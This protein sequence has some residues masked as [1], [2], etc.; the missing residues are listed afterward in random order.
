MSSDVLPEE[1]APLTTTL[2]RPV[3][4]SSST[5]TTASDANAGRSSDRSRKRRMDRHPPSGETGGMTAQT[6]DPSREAGVDDRCR[7]I[8]APTQR[9]QDALGDEGE[10]GG[11]DVARA[12]HLAVALDP[13]VAVTVHE[14]L[15]DGAVAEE[16]V[17]GAE[18]VET[19]HRRAHERF[20]G[21]STGERCHA[22]EVSANHGVGVAA[23]GGRRPGTARRPGARRR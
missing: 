17:E 6:R 19:G 5:A 20:T 8:E 3:T 16:R 21:G 10:V 7:A 1:V 18:P 13:H 23:L 11:G 15:V 22:S 12:G 2:H 4:S 9:S 14:D